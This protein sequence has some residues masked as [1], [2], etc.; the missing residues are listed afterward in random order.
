MNANDSTIE[1][2]TNELRSVEAKIA[3]TSDAGPLYLALRNARTEALKLRPGEDSVLQ[4]LLELDRQI[5]GC[6]EC[7]ADHYS[8]LPNAGFDAGKTLATRYKML[9][10]ELA[11]LQSK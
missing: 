7:F 5:A 3:A 1:S 8:Q 6:Q 11:E 2:L 9:R 10:R 4:W